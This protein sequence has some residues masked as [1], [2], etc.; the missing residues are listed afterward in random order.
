MP[1]PRLDL[2]SSTLALTAFVGAA[3]LSLCAPP[4]AV[5]L[6]EYAEKEAK[7]CSH[8]HVNP[9]GAGPRNAAGREY[10]ANGHVFGAKSWSSDENQ[11]QFL[12]A[13]SAL[14]ATWYAEA[15][16]A[17]AALD[18]V[19]KLAG[20]R[21]LIAGTRDRFKMFPRAWAGAARK[22]DAQ[23]ERGRP[24]RLEFL[25]KLESQFPGTTEGKAA[26]KALDELGAKDDTAQAVKDARAGESV[27]VQFLRGRMEWDLGNADD[28]R[29]LFKQVAEDP[30]GKVHAAEIEALLSGKSPK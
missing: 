20:G 10:E 14:V 16:R 4:V 15:E 19:E 28:A 2:V 22:L 6:P 1:R 8:C 9:K 26:T 18:G 23:G 25:A 29:A 3:L 5:A 13:S 27:R 30:L 7:D 17:L 24:K 12:R 11:Q 21:A